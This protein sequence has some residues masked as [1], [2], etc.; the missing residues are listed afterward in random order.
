[1]NIMW[2][3]R[4]LYYRSTNSMNSKHNPSSI[5]LILRLSL[6][7][8]QNQARS[9]CLDWWWEEVECMG[10]QAVGKRGNQR[11]LHFTLPAPSSCSDWCSTKLSRV[12]FRSLGRNN[13]GITWG[14]SPGASLGGTREYLEYTADR[15][16]VYSR[17]TVPSPVLTA[18]YRLQVTYSLG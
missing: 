15:C 14:P 18:G 7:S 17:H 11:G 5:Y 1:M 3:W 2:Q 4:L 6:Q 9:C 16:T 8:R 13:P 10:H 12:W